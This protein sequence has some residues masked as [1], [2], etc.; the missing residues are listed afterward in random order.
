[1]HWWLIIL[2][3]HY[4]REATSDWMSPVGLGCANDRLRWHRSLANRRGESARLAG[5][6]TG[7]GPG[8]PSVGGKSVRWPS[9][10]GWRSATLI[11]SMK[12]N[13]RGEDFRTQARCGCRML[14]VRH[15]IAVA[16]RNLRSP[17]HDRAPAGRDVITSCASSRGKKE[18]HLAPSNHRRLE[19]AARPTN[20]GPDLLDR[21][22]L[23]TKGERTL[24][25]SRA[26]A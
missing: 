4:V 1:M 22:R 2:P 8:V 19:S 20:S 5:S 17:D 11:D 23:R 12:S 18:P 3:G 15:A 16:H 9:V 13:S 6:G 24:R 26:N 25:R 7:L 10:A 21:R 14:G